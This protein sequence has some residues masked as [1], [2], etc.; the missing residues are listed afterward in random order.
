MSQR[1]I[2]TQLAGKLPGDLARL[3]V[4]ALVA[5]QAL[6]ALMIIQRRYSGVLI[7]PGSAA[8]IVAGLLAASLAAAPRAIARAWQ[9]SHDMPWFDAVVRLVPAFALLLTAISLSTH[10]SAWW[11]V[12]TFWFVAIAEEAFVWVL[13]PRIDGI[14]G[15]FAPARLPLGRLVPR[16]PR[17]LIPR[18]FVERPTADSLDP[19]VWQQTSRA[20]EDE[21]NDV[22][23]GRL[24]A[25]LATGQRTAHVHLAFCPQFVRLPQVEF[26]QLDGPAARVK[27]GQLLPYG[28]RLDV[29]LDAPPDAP[30]T[31]LLELTAR[32]DVERVGGGGGRESLS[33]NPLTCHDSR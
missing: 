7:D 10:G 17:S 20:Y 9:R 26:R 2:G 18:R 30:C 15:R 32:G 13:L 12:A 25:M 19:H 27:L 6:V 16:R 21:G 8:L 1:A 29:K 33:A 31:V 24:R 5:V 4:L 14:R 3:L 23:R 28:V 22:L 11:A